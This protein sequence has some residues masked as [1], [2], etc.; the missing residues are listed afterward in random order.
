MDEE[1]KRY[2]VVR[3]FRRSGLRGVVLRN[4]TKETARAHCHDP[5][6]S[7][8]TCTSARG[9]RRTARN[10]EWFDGFEEHACQR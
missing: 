2:D 9:K 1:E 8:R 5:E 10:G 7:S 4:V 3:F 6:T